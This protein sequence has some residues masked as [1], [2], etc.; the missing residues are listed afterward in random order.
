[1]FMYSH[2]HFN[3]CNNT[4]IILKTETINH[5]IFISP[6]FYKKIY[7]QTYPI[8]MKLICNTQSIIYIKKYNN[9]IEIIYIL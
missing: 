7:L 8:K 4:N 5:I 1:M 6:I 9:Y 3:Y 2:S